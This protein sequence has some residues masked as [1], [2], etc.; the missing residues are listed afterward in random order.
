MTVADLAGWALQFLVYGLQAAL[1]YAGVR[2]FRLSGGLVLNPF[3][4]GWGRLEQLYASAA[5]QPGMDAG[6]A[7]IG[8]VSYRNTICIGFDA[9]ELV[10]QKT[11]FGKSLLRI[12]YSRITCAMAPRRETILRIPIQLDGLFVVDGVSICLKAD[13]A[14]QLL[15]RLTPQ[16]APPPQP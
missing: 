4:P 2:L 11:W 14:R 5:A 16:P 10:L 3:Q 1:L 15:A 9:Q 13:L 12:P 6:S 8:M 7:R